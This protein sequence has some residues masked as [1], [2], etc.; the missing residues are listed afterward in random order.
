MARQCFVPS[1]S[2]VRLRLSSKFG[3]LVEWFVKQEYC[4]SKGGCSEFRLNG[5]GTDFFDENSSTTRCRF[6]ANY[7]VTHN[8]LLTEGFVSGTCEIRKRPVD[9]N[10]DE[11]ER[12]AVPDIITH[13]PGVRME[14]YE[15]KANS[16]AGKA[17]G[18]IKINDFLAMVD[19][20]RNTDPGVR[21]NKGTQ[22]DPDRSILIWDGT[23][24]GSPI[25]AFLHFVREDD[26]LI[27][28]DIC[29]EVSGEFLAEV[30]VKAIIKLAV[31]AVILLLAPAAAGGA[32][33][34]AWTSPMSNS[35]GP[36]GTNDS[37]DVRYVQ[38]LLSDWNNHVD[39]SLLA[40]DGELSDETINALTAF[41]GSVGMDDTAGN[42]SPG[43]DTL[44]VLE[45]THL[46]NAASSVTF[47]EM[48]DLGTEGLA[49]VVFADDPDGVDPEVNDEPDIVV[50]LSGEFE[51]YL[52]D[53][54]DSV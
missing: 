49:E 16:Q 10:D 26:A 29:I 21:Y 14:F 39:G 25:K 22:F 42:I 28:Y 17:A 36:D 8:P 53:V 45:R 33:V 43:D 20:L 18:R 23:W 46:E 30:F 37:Q 38:A 31:I 35:V 51:T 50:A 7:L 6:L 24:F 34:L 15:I 27:V 11:N 40:I 54:Y 41:Q 4:L 52:Q 12:F 2:G 1:E 13:E 44:A 47:S 19:F 3:H 48:L 9:E 32:V 5:S